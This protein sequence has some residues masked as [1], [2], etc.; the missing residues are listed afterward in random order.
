M[1]WYDIANIRVTDSPSVLIKPSKLET[2]EKNWDRK[3][4]RE[5]ENGRY[6]EPKQCSLDLVLMKKFVDSC[7]KASCVKRCRQEHRN[8]DLLQKFQE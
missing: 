6:A 2:R 5:L 4:S 8:S 7:Y 1:L 3:P